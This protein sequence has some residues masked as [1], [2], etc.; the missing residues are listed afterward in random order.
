MIASIPNAQSAIFSGDFFTFI[1]LNLFFPF[2]KVILMLFII[3]CVR[4]VLNCCICNCIFQL[5]DAVI[6]ADQMVHQSMLMLKLPLSPAQQRTTPKMDSNERPCIEIHIV[7]TSII[8][9]HLIY[10]AMKRLASNWLFGIE[11]ANLSKYP[12]KSSF[13]PSFSRCV[14]ARIAFIP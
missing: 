14:F 3:Y 2:L 5:F 10:V 6:Y 11:T 12:N 1:L 4:F 8:D 9:L 7:H 13:F